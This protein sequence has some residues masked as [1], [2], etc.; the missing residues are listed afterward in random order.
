MADLRLTAVD[1]E[2]MFEISMLTLP[3]HDEMPQLWH[4]LA[5]QGVANIKRQG[6]ILLCTMEFESLVQ[7]E[8]I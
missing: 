2:S 3:I 4:K 8:Q 7:K 5:R 6:N 1:D